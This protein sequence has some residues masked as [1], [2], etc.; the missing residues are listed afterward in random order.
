[1]TSQI[2]KDRIV[3]ELLPIYCNDP[4]RGLG[5][6]GF[7]ANWKKVTDVDAADFLLALDAGLIRHLG[8]G[9]Y[10]A[11]RSRASEIFFWA[12][13]KSVSPRPVTLWVEPIITVAVLSRLHFKWGWPRDLLGT[14]SA[15]W[16]FDVTAY[17]ATDLSIEYVACEVK[18]T[19]AELDQLVELM[20]RF[21][22]DSSAYEAGKA[23]KEKNA[24]NK[25]KGLKERRASIF[26]AVGPGGANRVF[27]VTYADGGLVTFRPAS[28]DALRY[29]GP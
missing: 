13:L 14:Q 29:P 24:F 28:V 25:L 1:M 4:S 2:F 19:V 17:L 23:A 7:K 6:E 12:G 3:G 8:G 22:A 9:L 27:R 18:K 21:A 16:E 11:P 20:Q 15:K 10:R 5:C 26:W